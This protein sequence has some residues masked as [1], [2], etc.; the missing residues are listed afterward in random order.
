[1]DTLNPSIISIVLFVNVVNLMIG[2]PI[3]LGYIPINMIK[4][5]NVAVLS[6]SAL[7]INSVM[8]FISLFRPTIDIKLITFISLLISAIWNVSYVVIVNNNPSCR[9]Y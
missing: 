1:M 8:C 3:I 2:V 7:I 6:S 4:I 5:L 9:I